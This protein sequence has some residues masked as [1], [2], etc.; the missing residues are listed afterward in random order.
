MNTKPIFSITLLTITPIIVL[1]NESGTLAPIIIEEERVAEPS[2][3]SQS[4]KEV[5]GIPTDAGDWLRDIPGVSGSR[6]GGH[7]IDPTIRGQSQTQLNILLDGAYVHG[8]CPNRMDP[9]T[10]YSPIESYDHITV[11][12]GSQTVRY[13]SGEHDHCR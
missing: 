6:M 2:I 3:S 8:G 1:A 4:P 10:A 9:S 11:M 13:G 7:G 12:K 5:L